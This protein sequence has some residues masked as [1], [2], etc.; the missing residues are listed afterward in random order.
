MKED[1]VEYGRKG[2]R[3]K[4]GDKEGRQKEMAEEKFQRNKEESNKN[5]KTEKENAEEEYKT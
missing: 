5:G 3:T 1:A 2:N 4:I